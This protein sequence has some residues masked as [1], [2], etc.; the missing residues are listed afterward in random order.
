MK[1]SPG[2]LVFLALLAVLLPFVFWA[3]LSRIPP[4]ASAPPSFSGGKTYP[5]SRHP[6]TFTDLP[7]KKTAPPQIT[8]VQV[9]DVDGDGSNDILYCDALANV[10]GCFQ[11]N[12]ENWTE[13]TLI[14]NVSVPAHATVVDIDGDGDLD[15]LA[16]VLGNIYPDDHVIG[17]VELY[18]NIGDSYKRHVLLDDVRRVADIQAGDL[19]GDGDIDLA[20]AVFG[21]TRGSILWLENLG[22]FQFRD[23][24][25]LNAPGTIHV[26]LADFDG[27]GDLDIAAIVTQDEEELWAFENLGGGKFRPRRLWMTVN[28][29][30][31]GA[32]LVATDLDGDNDIDLILPAGDNLEDLDAYPQPYH[33]CYW[34]ENQGKW[35]FRIHRIADLGGTYAASP[36]DLDNDGD[37]DI[38]LVS[39]ANDSYRNDTATVVWLE[40]D[41]QQNFT[42]WEI[43]T[44]PLNQVTVAV[45]DID[46]DDWN[47]IVTGGLNVRKP[48][49]RLG[50]VSLWMNEGTPEP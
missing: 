24:Q 39:M 35:D 42:T 12:G 30:L 22:D 47:D 1:S 48:F 11:W 29:D 15:I 18:E 33:G 40:N 37:Q 23:H 9:I 50:R 31:G 19:D 34:F 43:A 5:S 14:S 32:G 26:P 4:T 7:Q 44:S 38:V 6:F 46:G 3:T 8:N 17:R 45:G 16:S 41:G 2:L 20:V 36:G 10:I 49:H 28:Y 27:D 21:Y 13:K 25:L